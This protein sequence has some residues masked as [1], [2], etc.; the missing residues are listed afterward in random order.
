M[1]LQKKI[2]RLTT[3][4]QQNKS[5]QKT[6][7]RLINEMKRI[8]VYLL[9]ILPAVQLFSQEHWEDEF[10]REEGKKRYAKTLT[11]AGLY[12]AFYDNGKIKWQ[13]KCLEN[14]NPDSVWV[15]YNAEGNKLWEGEYNGKYYE[16][17]KHYDYSKYD[18][19]GGY[20]T[21]YWDTSLTGSYKN[22]LKDGEWHQYDQNGKYIEKIGHYRNGE[23]TGIWQDFQEVT[24]K[25]EIKKFAEYDYAT[26]TKKHFTN[27]TVSGTE[28][29]D[30]TRFDLLHGMN[31][32]NSY[33][34][35]SSDENVKLN[36]CG[37]GTMQFISIEPLN[38][39][40]HDSAFSK[41]RT[42]IQSIGFE[43][44]GCAENHM[45]WF[46]NLNWNP[47]VSAQLNDSIRLRLSGFSSNLNFGYDMIHKDVVDL[48]PTLGFGFQQLKLK[49]LKLQNPDSLSYNFNEGDYRIYR[50]S[51]PTLNA[52][53]TLRVNA[54]IFTIGV[55]GG[56]LFDC[57]SPKWRYNGKFLQDS[58]K[59]SLSGGY[60]NVS[61]GIHIDDY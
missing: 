56:Y 31:E 43:W 54:G 49:V 23:P 35:Y 13:G 47:A 16:Y 29:I 6:L 61:I 17:K 55:T 25:T 52:A 4:L 41:L 33:N 30:S 60:V 51:A 19:E 48:A 18:E 59:T 57:S 40:F 46:Y 9:L 37:V 24:V 14:G 42:D 1:V 36:V 50:N 34:D 32:G 12:T 22:G 26:Q 28:V 39:F 38:S 3:S 27:D 45:Y 2:G 5:N 15:Y 11:M 58:P 44:S 53:L 7:S 21:F 8:L 10:W 20:Q